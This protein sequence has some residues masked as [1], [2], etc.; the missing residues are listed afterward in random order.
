MSSSSTRVQ[1]LLLGKNVVE[2]PFNS[3]WRSTPL[4]Y[5]MASPW[6]CTQLAR[7]SQNVQD[8]ELRDTVSAT[9]SSTSAE[10]SST[11]HPFGS[12]F[13]QCMVACCGY[14]DSRAKLSVTQASSRAGTEAGI[15]ADRYADAAG[16][17]T[18]SWAGA[19]AGGRVPYS[20]ASNSS[21]DSE[22]ANSNANGATALVSVKGKEVHGRHALLMPAGKSERGFVSSACS[23]NRMN[24][25][26]PSAKPHHNRPHGIAKIASEMQESAVSRA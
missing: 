6:M 23:G 17:D 12:S 20:R 24:E 13:G 5:P 16:G 9:A 2:N 18:S 14:D 4:W 22:S 26:H 3:P 19:G 1:L 7:E 25:G 10:Q 11:L 8:R 21:S 15:A